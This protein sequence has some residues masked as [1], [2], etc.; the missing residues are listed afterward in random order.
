MMLRREEAH[1]LRAVRDWPMATPR[2]LAK[3]LEV[4]ADQ[5]GSWLQ[6][7]LAAGWV[8]RHRISDRY[9]YAAAEA[10]DRTG[11]ESRYTLSDAGLAALAAGLGVP[12]Q[13]YAAHYGV[14]R[15]R[16]FRALMQAETTWWLYEVL[17]EMQGQ[18]Y[19]LHTWA[20]APLMFPGP[21]KTHR[22]SRQPVAGGAS[23]FWPL[24]L[25]VA[26]LPSATT[27][28]EM[29]RG[30]VVEWDTGDVLPNAY[31]RRFAVLYRWYERL[32][33]MEGVDYRFPVVMMLTTTSRRATQLLLIW[34]S[35]ACDYGVRPLPLFVAP[36]R[37]PLT[38]PSIWRRP[39]APLDAGR[40]LTGVYGVGDPVRAVEI[41]GFPPLPPPEENAMG[42]TAHRLLDSVVLTRAKP[43]VQPGHPS[44]WN[45][46]RS[47]S[48]VRDGSARKA[49][50]VRAQLAISA[51]G[52]RILG[53]IAAWPLLSRREIVVVTGM[54]E[55]QVRGELTCLLDW[56]LIA[57][58]IA[59][60]NHNLYHLTSQGI[61]YLAATRGTTASWYAA[62]RQWPVKRIAGSREVELRLESL[63]VPYEHT[64]LTRWLFMTLLETAQYFRRERMLSHHL[65]VW[66]EAEARRHFFHRGRQRVLAPDAAGVYLIGDQTYE[67]LV[68]I[69]MGT[70]HRKS[71]LQKFAIFQDYRAS[72]A[73]HRDRV[74][75]PLILVVTSKGKDRVQELAAAIVE[76]GAGGAQDGEPASTGSNVGANEPRMR[77]LIAS[78]A[79]IE[80]HGLH[81][82]IW[83]EV[84]AGQHQQC[85]AGFKNVPDSARMMLNPRSV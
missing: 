10:A 2:Q 35:C 17:G 21:G 66:E 55:G 13:A 67:F 5:A 15:N 33:R 3:R 53:R 61:S 23:R 31:R 75:L 4:D 8:H 64:R 20:H 68:E 85:F 1:L 43:G 12:V 50:L 49:G 56:G 82:P 14:S 51:P 41:F 34:E 81:R 38:S 18:G 71:L 48:A 25:G 78:R 24:A 76:S 29:H 63:T 7:A 74:R 47:G 6:Q 36:W 77:F 11:E 30:V 39:E 40:L 46:S 69:D 57:S 52:R 45:I 60:D 79:D 58:F 42:G 19:Q 65:V 22:E 62:G 54:G 28:Q 44:P 16:H 73:Y 72:L 59:P 9:R 83:L 70:R 84:A 26:I 37:E 32:S 27:Q 80:R